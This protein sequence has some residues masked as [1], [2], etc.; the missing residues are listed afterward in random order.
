MIMAD[1]ETPSGKFAVR[2]CDW[3][4]KDDKKWFAVDQAEKFAATDNFTEVF[5]SKEQSVKL[6]LNYSL[7]GIIR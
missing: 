3:V 4:G 5:Q 6:F 1:F 2:L 7:L